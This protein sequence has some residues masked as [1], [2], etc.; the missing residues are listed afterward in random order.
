MPASKARKHKLTIATVV[1][2]AMY[3]QL[4]LELALPSALSPNN[5]GGAS[6]VD[7]TFT[8]L[9]TRFDAANI[10]SSAIF[11]RL[12]AIAKVEIDL[13][14]EFDLSSSV[15]EL[16]HRFRQQQIEKA[17]E[18]GRWLVTLQPDSVFCDGVI[19]RSLDLF[20]DGIDGIFFR[21]LR[22]A[23]ETF[24]PDVLTS[25]PAD[26]TGGIAIPPRELVRLMRCHFHPFMA[27]QVFDAKNFSNYFAETLVSP[28]V[29]DGR[30]VGFVSSAPFASDFLILNPRTRYRIEYNQVLTE[31]SQLD[32]IH[33]VTDSDEFVVAGVT[34]VGNYAEWFA[35]RGPIDWLRLGNLCVDHDNAFGKPLAKQRFKLHEGGGSRSAWAAAEM[36]SIISMH[37]V[38]V[39]SEYTFICRSMQ[40]AG[41]TKAALLIAYLLGS[42]TRMPTLGRGGTA[43][44]FVP[45]DDA[46]A[47]LD[48]LDALL[49]RDAEAL[50]ELVKRHIV[51]GL[52]YTDEM[53]GGDLRTL[54]GDT[55][56]AV[57]QEGSFVVNGARIL[58]ADIALKNYV[59]H[60]IAGFL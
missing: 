29:D 21:P 7:L 48:D 38:G 3:R 41:L 42:G 34:P 57:Q 47:G 36:R 31:G 20:D 45:I 1:W 58:H 12:E 22:V 35:D 10:R 37:R 16:Q 30:L 27:A 17:A 14:E 32:G 50:A 54:R 33:F 44:L 26:E 19:R 24:V 11:R 39:Q 8:I 56:Q 40:G 15:F 9:T 18:E 52:Y 6:D 60:N 2:G 53:I 5:L 13:R 55:I 46:F 59:V 49:E 25:F 28:A 4:F 43:T 51:P 23:A